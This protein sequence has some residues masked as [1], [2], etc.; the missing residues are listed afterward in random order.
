MPTTL[1][2]VHVELGPLQRSN[3]V[4]Y[5]SEAQ[6]EDGPL[7]AGEELVLRDE[8]DFLY[9]A[10]VD[11]ISAGTYGNRYRIKFTDKP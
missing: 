11:S 10:I 5:V 7:V 9:D 8:G 3:G 2:T 4:V 1:T 6:V